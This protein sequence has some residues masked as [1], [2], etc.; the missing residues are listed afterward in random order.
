MRQR[1]YKEN[2][3]ERAQREKE[4]REREEREK[5]PI[6]VED[7]EKLGLN[8]SKGGPPK[9][10]NDRKKK[11]ENEKVEEKITEKMEEEVEIF[12]KDNKK[13]YK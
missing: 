7:A 10:K 2:E 1:K 9:F 11:L 6:T 3:E 8:F 4:R 12:K 5:A 13:E